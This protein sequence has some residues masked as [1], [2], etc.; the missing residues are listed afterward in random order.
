[1]EGMEKQEIDEASKRLKKVK[2][3]KRE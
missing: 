3:T 2:D 1:M